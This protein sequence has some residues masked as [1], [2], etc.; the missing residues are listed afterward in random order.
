MLKYILLYQCQVW[1]DNGCDYFPEETFDYYDSIESAKSRAKSLWLCSFE[2]A[3]IKYK[4]KW[5]AFHTDIIIN[6]I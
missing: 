1:D 3:E 5:D 2:I 6:S 4:Q